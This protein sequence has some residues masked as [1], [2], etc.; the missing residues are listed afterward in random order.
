MGIG[1]AIVKSLAELHHG[2]ISVQSESGEGSCFSLS[3]PKQ[4]ADILI[5]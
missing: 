1:L 5:A 4:Q 3:L 2:R